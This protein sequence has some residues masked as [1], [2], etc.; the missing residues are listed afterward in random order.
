TITHGASAGV[1]DTVFFSGQERFF[2]RDREAQLVTAMGTQSPEHCTSDPNFVTA[3]F[4]AVRCARFDGTLVDARFTAALIDNSV[5]EVVGI[6]RTIAPSGIVS[7]ASYNQAGPAPT[8]VV[9]AG[10]SFSDVTFP[11]L[12]SSVGSGPLNVQINAQAGPGRCY[13]N[14]A[15]NSWGT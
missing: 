4:M 8:Q 15:Q 3:Q 1:Y 9:G 14:G 6:A 13:L 11:G 10:A 5:L 2:A 12:A 7:S